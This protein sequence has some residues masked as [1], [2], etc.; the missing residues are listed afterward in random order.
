M[1]GALEKCAI[2]TMNYV[3]QLKSLFESENDD[4]FK[5]YLFET[6]D[7]RID[8]NLLPSIDPMQRFSRIDLVSD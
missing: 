1:I 3:Y 4:D 7:S 5:N 8:N 2:V 6:I